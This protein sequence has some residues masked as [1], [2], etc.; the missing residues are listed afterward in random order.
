MHTRTGM[1]VNAHTPHACTQTGSSKDVPTHGEAVA[2]RLP[3]G[4]CL[5]QAHGSPQ[6]SETDLARLS[7]PSLAASTPPSAGWSS[8]PPGALAPRPGGR[9]QLLAGGRAGPGQLGGPGPVGSVLPWGEGTGSED[10]ADAGGEAPGSRDVG[11]VTPVAPGLV[12][13]RRAAHGRACA[14]DKGP[15]GRAEGLGG[16]TPLTSWTTFHP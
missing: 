10:P 9:L 16:S 11:K 15:S 7:P 14:S 8:A 2:P 1:Q 4:A 12:L 13:P 5:L 3:R 6:T